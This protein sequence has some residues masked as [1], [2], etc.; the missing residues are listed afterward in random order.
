MILY[1]ADAQNDTEKT[2]DTTI[3]ANKTN[4]IHTVSLNIPRGSIILNVTVFVPEEFLTDRLNH[5]VSN[6]DKVKVKPNKAEGNTYPPPGFKN[7]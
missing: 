5:V 1:F 2:T 4:T 3:S 6:S 7:S